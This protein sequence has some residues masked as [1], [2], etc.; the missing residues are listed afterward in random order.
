M[1]RD[2]HPIWCALRVNDCSHTHTHW[3]LGHYVCRQGVADTL[4]VSTAEHGQPSAPTRRSA[5]MWPTISH[6]HQ[7]G[8]ASVPYGVSMLGVAH[9]TYP[10]AT[11]TENSIVSPAQSSQADV[12]PGRPLAVRAPSRS[13]TC[14]PAAAPT[15]QQQQQT[16]GTQ[17]RRV[18]TKQCSSGVQADHTAWRRRCCVRRATPLSP[19][20]AAV[21]AG[22]TRL[23]DLTPCATCYC[24]HTS[25]TWLRACL[26]K[27]PPC[28]PP[29]TPVSPHFTALPAAATY[30]IL[31]G[32]VLA[33]S[34]P[35]PRPPVRTCV[36]SLHALPAAATHPTL[37]GFVPAS[38]GSAHSSGKKSKGWAQVVPR[39]L[40][41]GSW[42]GARTQAVLV[43]VDA[44]YGATG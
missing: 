35:S 29:S 5:S 13:T 18:A 17:Q 7:Q 12:G 1:A 32:S 6:Q 23:C 9:A 3:F 42:A 4:Q 34:P 26:L 11:R 31:N 8:S 33:T 25:R 41:V 22:Q 27:W 39:G 30:P 43:T 44:S 2:K 10:P 24:C 40:T 15:Q 36:T 19:R 16:V 28:L 21:M 37:N 20:A 38:S 14:T